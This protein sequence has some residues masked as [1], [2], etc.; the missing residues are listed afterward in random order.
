MRTRIWAMSIHYSLTIV[1][2]IFVA[3]SVLHCQSQPTILCNLQQTILHY[4]L[5]R[6]QSISVLTRPC[7][8]KCQPACHVVLC[9]RAAACPSRSPWS[10]FGSR[11]CCRDS[12]TWA[13]G[14]WVWWSGTCPWMHV[15]PVIPFLIWFFP[16]GGP[17][18]RHRASRLCRHR[19]ETCG[20]DVAICPCSCH[21]QSIWFQNRTLLLALPL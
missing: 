4:P 18:R 9:W 21:L 14:G 13:S 17:S 7:S 1:Q 12:R 3:Q 20:N 16:F 10:S 8:A 2:Y 6:P 15:A 5:K 11:P 19:C